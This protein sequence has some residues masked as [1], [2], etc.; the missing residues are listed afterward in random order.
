M[1]AGRTAG[2]RGGVWVRLPLQV[3]EQW[4]RKVL[5]W[6]FVAGYG[7][8]IATVLLFVPQHYSPFIYFRF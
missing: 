7:A 4:W 5:E 8:A 6:A 2:N 3:F 1:F